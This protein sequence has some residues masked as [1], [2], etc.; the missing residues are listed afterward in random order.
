MVKDLSWSVL[1]ERKKNLRL[2]LLFKI[3]NKTIKLQF[4]P[5]TV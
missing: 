2:L 3:V 1:E 5:E 4:C